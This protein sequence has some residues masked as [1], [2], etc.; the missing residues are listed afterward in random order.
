MGSMAVNFARMRHFLPAGDFD[1]SAHQGELIKAIAR[2]VSASQEKPGF[3]ERALLAVVNDLDTG[4][5][6]AEIYRLAHAVTAVRPGRLQSC[7]LDGSI[8]NVG[9]ASIVFPDIAEA[10]A[11]GN[12]TRRDA[13]LNN[14]RICN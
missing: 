11:F 1:R 14:R 13:H 3:M 7:V 9:G 6:P 5:S 10:R 8:G 4:L 2:K 12:D